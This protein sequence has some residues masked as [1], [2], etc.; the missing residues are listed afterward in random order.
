MKKKIKIKISSKQYELSQIITNKLSLLWENEEPNEE[1]FFP[2]EQECEENCGEESPLFEFTTVGYISSGNGRTEIT[3]DESELTGMEGA[4]T[5]L[6]FETEAPGLVTMLRGGSV[7]TAMVFEGRRRHICIYETPLMP[8]ELCI[9]T[10]KVE[11]TLLSDG[12][13]FLDYVVEFKGAQ[14]ERTKFSIE[15]EELTET[16][17]PLD[18]YEDD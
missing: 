17:P 16:K 6:S 3:Y 8:F 7:T 10:L 5:A 13:L 2:A 11:N 12:K 15:I 1:D 9:H 4:S 14:A 18:E